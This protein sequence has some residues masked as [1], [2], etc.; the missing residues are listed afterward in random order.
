MNVNVL[1]GLLARITETNLT[2]EEAMELKLAIE[3]IEDMQDTEQ[4][5]IDAY[6]CTIKEDLIEDALWLYMTM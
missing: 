3:Y 6:G 4:K 5:F 2:I 1:K